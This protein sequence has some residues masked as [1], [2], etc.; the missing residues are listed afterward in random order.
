[1]HEPLNANTLTGKQAGDVHSL[2]NLEMNFF[3]CPSDSFVM[4]SPATE[5]ERNRNKD[6]V[7]VTLS[8]SYWLGQ[9][10]VT[11]RQWEKVMS[12]TPWSGQKDVNEGAI[13]PATYVDWHSAIE[14]SKKLTTR[15][16]A[17]GRLPETWSFRL[18]T[19]AEWEYAWFSENTSD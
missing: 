14:F 18:P 13:Y 16:R 15:E 8:H 1:M 9:T 6:Q 17:A 11:Q 2:M 10:E 3:W 5:H 19:E 7:N 4:G 12:T